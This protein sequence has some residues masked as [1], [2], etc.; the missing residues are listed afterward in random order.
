MPFDEDLSAFIDAE[1]FA[2]AATYTPQ[3]GQPGTLNGI[4]DAHYREALDIGGTM[5]VFLFAT[6][7]KPAAA[8]GDA[9]TI[10]GVSY[11]VSNVE[12]NPEGFPGFSLLKLQKV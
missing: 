3:G 1:E 5:P 8:R 10:A 12:P 4:F 9:I 11:T 2:H 7:D 6:A